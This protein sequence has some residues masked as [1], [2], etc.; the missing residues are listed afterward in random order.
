MFGVLV[1]LDTRPIYVT[2]VGSKYHSPLCSFITLSLFHFRL[3]TYLFHKSYPPLPRSFTSSS[4]T[5]FADYCMDRF[6]WA[7]RFLFLFFPYFFRFCA[8]R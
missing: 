8:M 3:K 7:T 6:S 2:F 5:A 4:R 1:P